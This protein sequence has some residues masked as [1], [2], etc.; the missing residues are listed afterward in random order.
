MRGN[1]QNTI[2]KRV[3]RGIREAIKEGQKISMPVD[4]SMDD[5]YTSLSFN[6][7]MLHNMYLTLDSAYSM[8][9]QNFSNS[10]DI[11]SAYHM[12]IPTCLNMDFICISLNPK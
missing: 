10:Q 6:M 2:L 1:I 8:R 9:G 11:I 5:D 7:I 12:L 4:M 3:D